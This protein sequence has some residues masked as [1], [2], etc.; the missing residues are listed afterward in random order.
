MAEWCRRYR[1]SGAPPDRLTASSDA[2]QPAP[3]TLLNQLRDCVLR[4][5]IALEDVFP[6]VTSN[7]AAVL[8]L[9]SKGR[10]AEGGDADLLALDAK[11]LQP[12]CVIAG[13]RVMMRDGIITAHDAFLTDTDR[14]IE[15]HGT[16]KS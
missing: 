1:E 5:R 2:G 13:G 8:K 9:P 4:N 11:T 6:V 14:R 12:R 16:K 7:T 3:S 10:L 15:L